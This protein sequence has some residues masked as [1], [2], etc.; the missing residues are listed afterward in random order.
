[1]NYEI[2]IHTRRYEG[3]QSTLRITELTF[4]LAN[5]IPLQPITG[6]P[7][8]A[9]ANVKPHIS[10]KIE[11]DDEIADP[12]SDAGKAVLDQAFEHLFDAVFSKMLTFRAEF[13]EFAKPS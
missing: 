9:Y 8:D 12:E 13:R 7:A 11:F 5:T 1:M 4:S 6:D 3:L 10:A 2:T